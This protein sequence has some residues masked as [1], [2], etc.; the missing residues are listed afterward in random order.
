MTYFKTVSPLAL[1]VF[2]FTTTSQAQ[3]FEPYAKG[4]HVSFFDSDAN[5]SYDSYRIKGIYKIVP[6]RDELSRDL[7]I[8]FYASPVYG[9]A[10]KEGEIK[11]FTA[12]VLSALKLWRTIPIEWK[13]SASEGLEEFSTVSDDDFNIWWPEFEDPDWFFTDDDSLDMLGNDKVWLLKDNDA[14]VLRSDLSV[15]MHHFDGTLK[16]AT[17][18]SRDVCFVRSTEKDKLKKVIGYKVTMSFVFQTPIPEFKFADEA[19]Y[20]EGARFRFKIAYKDERGTSHTIGNLD[21]QDA[22]RGIRSF[23]H[24]WKM[25]W[26]KNKLKPVAKYQVTRQFWSKTAGKWIDDHGGDMAGGWTE[27]ELALPPVEVLEVSQTAE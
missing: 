6:A 11:Y 18:L 2:T 22:R 25:K 16:F 5:R 12:S 26:C 27:L 17:E 21:V 3:D 7:V 10:N 9:S 4:I 19:R 15:V 23:Q 1:M 13:F 20:G 14:P 24:T 8:P